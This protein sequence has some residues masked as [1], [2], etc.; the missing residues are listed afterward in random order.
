[1]IILVISGSLVIFLQS[2]VLLDDT[3]S[4]YVE[5]SSRYIGAKNAMKL[6]YTGSN[7]TIAVID[8]GVDFNHP[9]LFGFGPNG[10][11]IGGYNF[12]KETEPPL[13]TNGHGTEVAG[14][15]SAKGNISGI[16]PNSNILAYKV[17]ENGEKVASEL[18]IKAIKKS[19]SDGA[20]IINI[21]LGVN[22]TNSKIDKAVSEAIDSGVL[23]IVAAGN[24]GPTLQT[25]GSPGTNPEA[26][27]V[28][29]T[30]NNVTASLVATLEIEGKQYN[31]VPMLGTA[32][33]DEPIV[34][35]MVF[36]KYGRERDLTSGNYS[37]KIMLVERG[38]DVKDELVYFSDKEKNAANAGAV[39]LVVY[40]NEEGIFFGELTH[41]FVESGYEPRIPVVSISREEGIEIKELIMQNQNNKTIGKLNVFFNPDYVAHFS[42]RGPV[43][44]FYIKPDIM[45]PGVFV[46][47][48]LTDSRYNFTSGTSFAA[49]HV[50]GA[51]ALLMQKNPDLLRTE[52]KSLL[53]TTADPVSDA[54]G[55]L[56]SFHEAG[57]GRLN[58]TR[59]I[60]ANM[61]MIPTSLHFFLSPEKKEDS[62]TLLLNPFDGMLDDIKVDISSNSDNVTLQHKI[63]P[64]NKIEI[65]T[66]INN[67]TAGSYEA[68]LKITE[69]GTRYTVPVIV[70]V[71]EATINASERDGR[72]VFDVLHPKDWTYSKI[73][74]INSK[75]AESRVT[76][77]T[78]TKETAL[79]VKDTGSYWIDAKI[80]VNGKSIDAYDIIQVDA[81]KRNKLF[82][83]F[84]DVPFRP[85]M[86]VATIAGI[87]AVFGFVQKRNRQTLH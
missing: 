25:I 44:P 80:R 82:S 26:I 10:K 20:D 47:T 39:G 2:G 1:M 58:V 52:I 74:V 61:A 28:G 66:S 27:T 33:F 22:R 7:I 17:S 15:I 41:E 56:F 8:T 49:P 19:I 42:S 72:I 12:I 64:D 68:L 32:L 37:G 63:R 40:N 34:G 59:A 38:S 67:A 4:T 48:T 79:T 86:I 50:S 60:S 75:T 18:I 3:A 62:K 71:T 87:I 70:Y 23:V 14:V 43:S 9:D 54:Y 31:V 13:D 55:N 5:K 46:N 73:S 85:I 24:N 45:A 81:V 36:G 53:L 30:Y 51:A 21:S 11:V 6:G 69:E 83:V 65:K 84:A 29:A 77:I 78:P 76:S 35:D 16:A 57:W